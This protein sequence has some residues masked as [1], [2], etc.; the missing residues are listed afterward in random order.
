MIV[1][2]TKRPQPGVAVVCPTR[3][4]LDSGLSAAVSL[5][6]YE[7]GRLGRIA[8]SAARDDYL[9]AHLLARL[10][11]AAVTGQRADA[12]R[13]SQ[14]CAECDGRDHGKPDVGTTPSVSVSGSTAA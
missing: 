1:A 14:R 12:I 3:L 13:L 9:A 8:S 11:V 7:T 6:L 10:V 5:E 2:P 4:V